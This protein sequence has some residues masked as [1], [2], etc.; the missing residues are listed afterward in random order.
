MEDVEKIAENITDKDKKQ[1]GFMFDAKNFYFNYPFLFSQGGYIF[2][3]KDNGFDTDV[4]V[5]D[6]AVVESGKDCNHGMKK[7]ISQSQH[8]KMS[9]LVYL[10][11]KVGMFVTGPG[12][13][14]V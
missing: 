13:L 3:E 14:Q 10:R 1:Y 2:K 7:V 6:K 4:A 9:L 11:R 8:I 12:K 5:N